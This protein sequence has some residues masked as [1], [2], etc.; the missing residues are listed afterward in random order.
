M[1][2]LFQKGKSHH[3]KLVVGICN[4]SLLHQA[5]DRLHTFIL[6]T[7]QLNFIK[8]KCS[9]LICLHQILNLTTFAL[10]F[11][12]K[13]DF[14]RVLSFCID[15]DFPPNFAHELPMSNCRYEWNSHDVLKNGYYFCSYFINEGWTSNGPI[16]GKKFYKAFFVIYG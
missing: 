11:N 9:K 13:L 4:I 1:P 3:L 2:S 8:K 5:R 15:S 10:L 14:P 16:L 7:S 6:C 12:Y